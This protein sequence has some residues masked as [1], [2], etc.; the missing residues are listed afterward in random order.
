[1]TMIEGPTG[2]LIFR[3]PWGV[4]RNT[5]REPAASASEGSADYYRAREAAERAAAKR[6]TCVKA[7]SVHQEL[8]QYYARR[9]GRRLVDDPRS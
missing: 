5:D 1:M 6:A 9:T 2:F 7:R 8:A 4:A 3:E